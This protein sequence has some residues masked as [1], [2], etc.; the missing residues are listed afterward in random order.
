M[1]NKK[2]KDKQLL[3]HINSKQLTISQKCEQH[4][5]YYKKIHV[6]CVYKISRG[7]LNLIDGLRVYASRKIRRMF[8]SKA[9]W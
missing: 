5:Q 2:P 9:K 8:A 7:L 4:F 1:Q 3:N 6:Q